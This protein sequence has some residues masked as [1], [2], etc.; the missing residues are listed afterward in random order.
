MIKKSQ[1][2]LVRNFYLG[3]SEKKI[4]RYSDGWMRENVC[5]FLKGGGRCGRLNENSQIGLFI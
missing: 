4:D 1:V 5:T 3:F 2:I